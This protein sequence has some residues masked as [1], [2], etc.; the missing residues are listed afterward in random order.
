[1]GRFSLGGF[2]QLSGYEPGQIDGNYLLFGRLTYTH[3]LDQ[4]PVLTRGW[5]AGA[6][7]EAGNAWDTRSQASLT[8]LRL[9][10]SLFVGAATG[11]GPLYFSLTY[12]PRGSTG[13]VLFIGRP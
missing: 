13:M 8:D 6:T 7:L 4:A 5:F 3:R 2:H 12:A 9:G 1:M 11:L 10:S